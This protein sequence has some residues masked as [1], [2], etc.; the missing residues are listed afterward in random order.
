MVKPPDNSYGVVHGR[1]Y[2]CFRCGNLETSNHVLGEID[3]NFPGTFIIIQTTAVDEYIIYVYLCLIYI[4]YIH[5][6]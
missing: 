1:E 2:E 6:L 3:K 4:L 5:I